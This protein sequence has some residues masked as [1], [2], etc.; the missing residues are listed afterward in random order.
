MQNI[1]R[2]ELLQV[3]V[4]IKSGHQFLDKVRTFLVN[5]VKEGKLQQE[6]A[7]AYFKEILHIILFYGQIH[8]PK[9]EP[10]EIL[11][12]SQGVFSKKYPGV[13]EKCRTHLPTRP[14]F[15]VLLDAVVEVVQERR[16]E[17]VLR[18]LLQQINEMDVTN[19]NNTPCGNIFV[20]TVINFCYFYDKVAKMRTPNYFGASVSC[21]GRIPREIMIDTL[22]YRTWHNAISRAVCVG[23]EYNKHAFEFPP[24]VLSM[25]FKIYTLGQSTEG[26]QQ[27][28]RILARFRNRSLPRVLLIVTK[29]R[30]FGC[31]VPRAACERCSTMFPNIQFHPHPRAHQAACWEYGN[32]AECESLS[33]LLY[34]DE[35]LATS[36]Q[37]E[38][39]QIGY[40]E[41]KRRKYKRLQHNLQQVRFPVEPEIYFYNN[42]Q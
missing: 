34:S 33:Q 6:R 30:D 13:F 18:C 21:K 14:P 37:Y 40:D 41:L 1:L 24:E 38:S 20:S 42:Q 4:F 12:E 17:N 31:L 32:C 28:N 7:K 10:E 26:N 35:Q 29:L 36:L 2:Y 23:N 8:H 9:I 22:C 19:A 5:A 3:Q 27:I 16:E 11:Q 25:A 39:F 15:T